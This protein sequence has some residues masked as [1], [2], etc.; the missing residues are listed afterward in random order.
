ML[1]PSDCPWASPVVFVTRFWVNYRRLNAT[2]VNDAYPLPCVDDSLRLL[3]RQQWFPRW[4]QPVATGRWPCPRMLAGNCVCYSR[5]TLSI[6]CDALRSLQCA[7][8]VRATHVLSGVRWSRCLVYLDDMISFGTN[9]PEAMLRLTEVLEHLSSFGV[10]SCRLRWLFSLATSSVGPVWNATQ[11]N[12]QCFGPGIHQTWLNRCASFWVSLDT[13]V[14]SFLTLLGCR[15][16]W[17]P[18]L[19]KGLY[20]CGL[21]K[22]RLRLTL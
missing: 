4:T 11:I 10:R 6:S 18:G 12:C 19:A 17:W 9:T 1:E 14:G 2:T 16:R 13:I 7:G 3:G 15:N 8:D 20:S 22:G 21:R 5:R